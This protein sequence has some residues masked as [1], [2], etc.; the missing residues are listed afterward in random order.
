MIFSM[1]TLIWIA[2][3]ILFISSV[4][5]QMNETKLTQAQNTFAQEFFKQVK[6]PGNIL[7]SPLSVHVALLMVMNGARGN[8]LEQMQNVLKVNL[9]TD[10]LNQ[11]NKTMQA[12][13]TAESKLANA[14]WVQRDFRIVP[15][16]KEALN[17]YFNAELGIANFKQNP[18]QAR[19]EINNWVSNK[20]ENYIQ[21]LFPQGTIDESTRSVIVNALFFKGFWEK[22]FDKSLTRDLAFNKYGTTSKRVPMMHKYETEE[23]LHT[24][25]G[26]TAVTLPYRG[27]NFKMTFMLPPENSEQS[28]SNTIN[29]LTSQNNLNQILSSQ[30]TETKLS[31]L[32]IPRFKIKWN[33][34]LKQPL[35]EMG[36]A[37][38]FSSRAN[39]TGISKDEELSISAVRHST[40]I[41]VDEEGTRAA[42]ATGVA[43]GITGSN[44]LEVC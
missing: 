28:M 25:N 31:R 7:V 6:A 2:I 42:A 35:S 32:V 41:E 37:E 12:L 30:G 8:S 40:F 13:Q 21:N 20:T 5:C 27:E 39:F 19:N 29:F 1:R 15:E 38:V 3:L 14:F 44:V 18:E 36:M 11:I 22:Q 4:S 17:N 34:D 16:F 23:L 10:T 9:T 26:I 33:A 24:V 43:I